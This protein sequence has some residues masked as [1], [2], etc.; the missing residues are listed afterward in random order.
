MTQETD[1]LDEIRELMGDGYA[2]L[3]RTY[4]RNAD[5]VLERLTAGQSDPDLLRVVHSL[6]SSSRCMGAAQ[7]G[8]AAEKLE[9]ALRAGQADIEPL[10][11]EFRAR[12][13]AARAFYEKESG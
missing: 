5:E 1:K 11:A 2:P 4:I 9:Q 6:K 10:I 13:I 8:A 3:V 12:W 7:V